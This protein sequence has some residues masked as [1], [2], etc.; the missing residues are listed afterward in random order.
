MPIAAKRGAV[1]AAAGSE[2]GI[3]SPTFRYFPHVS[4]MPFDVRDSCSDARA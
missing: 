3:L 4:A 1:C 2:R